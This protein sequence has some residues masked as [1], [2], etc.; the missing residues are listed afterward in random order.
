MTM[1]IHQELIAAARLRTPEGR[2]QEAELLRKIFPQPTGQNHLNG[3]SAMDRLMRRVMFPANGCWYWLGSRDSGGYGTLPA[4][5][6]NKAHR[7]AYRL[8]K[9]AIPKGA[10][11]MHKCD[12]RCCVNP[13]HLL[14]GTQAENIADM[15]GK[16]RHRTTPQRGEANAMAKL[17]TESVEAIRAL[18]AAGALQIDLARQFGVSPMTI[19]R[20]V[21]KETWK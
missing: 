20:A 16:G 17:T 14:T 7:V 2:M 4:I 1:T 9:G 19:S 10:K 6:E 8:F 5:G 12:T 21:R 18:K 11:V 13:D 15:M 3:G